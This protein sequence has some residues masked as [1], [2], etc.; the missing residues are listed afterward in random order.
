MKRRWTSQSKISPL[1]FFI[2][3]QSARMTINLISSLM[4]ITCSIK[5]TTKKSKNHFVYIE[6]KRISEDRKVSSIP[7]W[8]YQIDNAVFLLENH[9]SS[10]KNC[11]LKNKLSK[12]R[13]HEKGRSC[14]EAVFIWWKS[15]VNL[16]L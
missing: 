11:K 13:I 8:K 14:E 7:D 2:R 1:V 10:F 4:R 5:T 16:R 9:R 3:N 12:R 6:E 15:F